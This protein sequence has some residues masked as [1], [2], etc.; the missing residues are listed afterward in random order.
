MNKPL[1]VLV[2]DDEPDVVEILSYNLSRENYLVYKAYNGSD[3]VRVA[4]EVHPD[5]VI[6]DIRMPGIN[7]IEACRQM[8]QDDET[9]TIPVLF[10]TADADEYTTMNAIEAGGDHFITKP[11]RPQILMGMIAE[12]IR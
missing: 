2:V 1:K 7:G 9:K 12:L 4:H 10:L 11:I 5:L 6:M 8:K 3:G